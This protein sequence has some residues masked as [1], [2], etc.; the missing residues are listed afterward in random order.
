MT[1]PATF[2]TAA[3]VA[4][5]LERSP[6]R[7]RPREVMEPA[8]RDVAARIGIAEAYRVGAIG[9][10]DWEQFGDISYTGFDREGNLYVFDSQTMEIVV[11]SPEGRL[12][13][14]F[15]GPGDGPGEL[16]FARSMAVMRD[17]RVVITD[18]GHGAYV[19]F[20]P[21]GEYERMVS[22]GTGTDTGTEMAAGMARLSAL[23][24][25][26]A[27]PSS[28]ALI[29]VEDAARRS[30]F[31]LAL[32]ATPRSPAVPSVSS[33][34]CFWDGDEAKHD[35]GRTCMDAADHDDRRW[36]D[37]VCRRAFKSR[38]PT[39]S[40]APCE[41][42][43]RPSSS[44]VSTLAPCPTGRSRLRTPRP[45][46][47]RIARE[48]EG[49]DPHS[50]AAHPAPPRDRPRRA[51]LEGATA[52]GTRSR[53]GGRRREPTVQRGHDSHQRQAEPRRRRK[54]IEEAEFYEK[55]PSCV[56]CA[57]TWNG[58][59]WVRRSAEDR[60]PG[61]LLGRALVRGRVRRHLFRRARASRTRSAPEGCGIRRVGRVRRGD[62]PGGAFADGGEL[63]SSPGAGHHG[64][65]TNR[66]RVAAGFR[67]SVARAGI[68]K[69]YVAARV[70]LRQPL[71]PSPGRG[72]A[73]G[74]AVADR[75]RPPPRRAHRRATEPAAR[76][77]PT[78]APEERRRA[79]LRPETHRRPARER[80]RFPDP[81][82]HVDAPGAGAAAHAAHRRSTS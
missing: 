55:C 6:H 1:S 56:V 70:A 52:A 10:A 5:S 75:P 19:V 23:K 16:R 29:A 45:T 59:I 11:V 36:E 49:R 65:R 4:A 66:G 24:E 9:G 44:P 60:K 68:V 25:G 79:R 53:P 41:A 21:D 13:R 32:V 81:V 7:Q 77:L 3:A 27:D 31:R 48:G 42:S 69:R 50:Y 43:V 15:G 76:R 51:S 80:R 2:A 18:I 12:V 64:G 58:R 57:R 61:R 33:N 17:G 39:R 67:T 47:S 28:L 14:R 40:S 37:R 62:D 38:A 46:R 8:W 34:E 54:F 63:A 78:D 74:R 73:L 82:H 26:V 35:H 72:Q 22:T 71:Q 30:P 20:G